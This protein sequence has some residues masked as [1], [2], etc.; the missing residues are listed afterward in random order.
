NPRRGRVAMHP[1]EFDPG[2]VTVVRP[3]PAPGPGNWSGAATAFAVGGEVWLTWRERRPLDAGRGVAVS[4][5][6]SSD[7]VTFERVATVDREVFG[8]ESLERPALVPLP[9]GR[10][11]LYLS[12]A[13]P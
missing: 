4:I 13:T 12:C 7:G 6:R 11:R 5:A 9:D 1:L 2:G 10:W 3:A 8:A